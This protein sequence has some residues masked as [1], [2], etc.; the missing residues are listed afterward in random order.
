MFSTVVRNVVGKLLVTL[1]LFLLGSGVFADSDRAKRPFSVVEIE[2]AKLIVYVP[3]RPEWDY[4]VEPRDGTYAVILTT[5]EK[6]YPQASMEIILNHRLD[7]NPLN[8]EVTA[9]D[10]LNTIRQRSGMRKSLTKSDLQFVSFGDIQAYEDTFELKLKGKNFSVKSIMGLM[11]SGHPI[12][13]FIATPKG[14]L[15]HIKVITEKIFG[16]LKEIQ[17][18]PSEKMLRK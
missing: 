14:Q 18:N 3:A 2:K 5:P 12:T 13:I 4:S 17:S 11:P 7:I 8:F 15:K 10:A 1:V 16:K 6:F 9:L